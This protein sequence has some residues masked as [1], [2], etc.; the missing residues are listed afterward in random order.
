M[1]VDIIGRFFGFRLSVLV[2]VDFPF[3][4]LVVFDDD[5]VTTESSKSST[6]SP[7]FSPLLLIILNSNV[8]PAFAYDLSTK[9]EFFDDDAVAETSSNR[10]TFSFGIWPSMLGLES[11]LNS[12]FDFSAVSDCVGE[13]NA[14]SKIIHTEDIRI[15]WRKSGLIYN[16]S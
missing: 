6:F 14:M 13:D 1:S 10:L 12:T 16:E 2:K 3:A 11:E 4:E 5:A 7:S 15:V 8:E 9:T